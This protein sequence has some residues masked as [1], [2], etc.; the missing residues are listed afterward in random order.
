[1]LTKASLEYKYELDLAEIAKIWRGGC[2]IRSS[3]L[4]DIYQAYTKNTCARSFIT[5]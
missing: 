5:R 4:E 1:M 3:F 2:I